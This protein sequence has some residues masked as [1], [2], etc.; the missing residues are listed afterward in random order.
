MPRRRVIARRE[1]VG[2]ALYYPG[3][4]PETAAKDIGDSAVLEL[5]GLGG[6]AAAGSPAVAAFLGGTMADARKATD[7][8]IEKFVAALEQAG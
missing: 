4:G 1:P 5:V 3:Y 7:Q 6:P 8:M 2:D